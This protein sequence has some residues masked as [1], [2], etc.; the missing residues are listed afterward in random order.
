MSE[1][2]NI[3]E[4]EALIAERVGY[5]AEN[6]M[7]ERGGNSPAYGADH[8]FELAGRMR[9]LMDVESVKA[10][11]PVE[12]Q[13]DVEGSPLTVSVGAKELHSLFAAYENWIVMSCEPQCDEASY[14][15]SIVDAAAGLIRSVPGL[16]KLHGGPLAEH[17]KE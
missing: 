9:A 1:L 15:R 17:F 10:E 7:R 16:V 8:F 5:E 13:G 6:S 4:L 2:N 3:I 12:A 14:L 11:P